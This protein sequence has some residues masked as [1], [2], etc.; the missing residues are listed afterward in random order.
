MTQL[1]TT[2]ARVY[3]EMYQHIF[4]YDE[5]F[6]FYDDFL[7]K[8]RCQKILEVGCGSGMLARRFLANGYDYTGLDVAGEMLDIAREEIQQDVFVQ[9]DMRNLRFSNEFDAV[10]ITGRSLAYVTDNK[11]IVDT[12]TG[13]HNALKG[14]RLF[15]FG[16]FE[17]QGIFENFGDFE[18]TI[19]LPDKKIQ[20]ISHLEK[21][22]ETGWTWNWQARYIIESSGKVTEHEDKT[23]LRAF[24]KDEILLFLKLT[25]F[26]VVEIQE[27]NKAMTLITQK[28]DKSFIKP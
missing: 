2:L 27:E 13:I 8:N 7:R 5:E 4:D 1:Y 6:R 28:A 19:E 20:R 15:V 25:G 18:Q 9:S 21:N 12:L 3:H 24:T 10:L 23:T 17:A 26:D 16:V 22:L 11:G 14:N